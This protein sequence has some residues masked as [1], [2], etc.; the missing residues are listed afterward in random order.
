LCRTN[1]TEPPPPDGYSTSRGSLV[2]SFLLS[3]STHPLQDGLGSIAQQDTCYA[4]FNL[5]LLESVPI[6]TPNARIGSLVSTSGGAAGPGSTVAFQASAGAPETN[7]LN[8]PVSPPLSSDTPSRTKSTPQIRYNSLFV[9]NHGGGRPLSSRSLIPSER[10][11]GCMS[12][13]IDGVDMDRWP[14]IIHAAADFEALLRTFTLSQTSEDAFAEQL[15]GVL[16]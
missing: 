7:T 8:L 11:C 1:I 15:F 4:G 5:L 10:F 6:E 9:T 3:R 12:N 14:R 16:A 2:S 13:G